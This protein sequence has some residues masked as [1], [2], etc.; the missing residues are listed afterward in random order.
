MATSAAK[1]KVSLKLYIDKKS[2]KVVFADA[3]KDFVDFL[4]SILSLPMG[5]RTMIKL[6]SQDQILGCM[7]NL[8]RSIEDLD[9]SGPPTTNKFYRCSNGNCTGNYVT[10]IYGQTCPY[11][12]C[13]N[14]MSIAVTFK[15]SDSVKN[16]NE[17]GLVKGDQISYMVM[18]D[19]D[20]KP[21]S[22]ITIATLLNKFNILQC[23]SL[24]EKVVEIGMDEGLKLLKASLQSKT[25]L[26][27]V[28]L[29]S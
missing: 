12:F 13:R 11:P 15:G 1:V 29:G 9:D 16:M 26:T 23:S 7:G 22:L 10:D 25:V 5:T 28:F 4:F 6:L 2:N 20:V 14:S 3:G 8:Y 17:G 21:L 19:L 18:D 24:E 27:S